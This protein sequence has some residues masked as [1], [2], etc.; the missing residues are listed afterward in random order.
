[1]D[2]PTPGKPQLTRGLRRGL[3]VGLG[4]LFVGLAVLGAVL[5]VLPTTPFLLLASYFFVRSSPALHARLLRSRWFGPLLRDWQEHRAVRPRVKVLA[6]ALIPA[7]IAASILVGRL[8]LPLTSLLLALG[9]VGM[10]V[11][12]RLPVLRPEAA[13]CPEAVPSSS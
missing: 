4:C 2:T 7:V 5:P 12:W 8:S 11:V 10:V 3:Y 6:L 13:K 1:M 9:A